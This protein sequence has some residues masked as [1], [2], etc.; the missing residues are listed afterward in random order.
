ML[1][2]IKRLSGQARARW[3]PFPY[4]FPLGL[5]FLKV[6]DLFAFCDFKSVHTPQSVAY[7]SMLQTTG[8]IANA[9]ASCGE[10]CGAIRSI[11][12]A[13]TPFSAVAWITGY[14]SCCQMKLTL[15]SLRPR[16]FT[17]PA[18]RYGP[19]NAYPSVHRLGIDTEKTGAGTSK[20][21]NDRK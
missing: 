2:L 8:N 14:R 15:F 21:G 13:R 7:A 18:N 3:R 6:R 4:P 16:S 11:D 9:I 20:G 1:V 5:R 19:S 17:E 10:I 12:P